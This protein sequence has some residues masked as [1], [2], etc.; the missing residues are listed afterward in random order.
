M[1][2]F[3]L[4]NRF[5]E[6]LRQRASRR[7]RNRLL[8]KRR[9]L[10]L[11]SLENRAL[12]AVDLN[13]GDVAVVGYNTGGAPDQIA[14]VIL[15][16]LDE[17]TVFYVND[18]EVSS[19]GGTGFTD[20]NE[21]E[22][23][24]TVKAGQTVTAGTVVVL[25]WG[26]A[27]V[28]TP[29]YTWSATTGAGLGNNNEELYIY[30]APA[31]TSQTPTE[32]IYFAKIGTSVSSIPNGLVQGDTA[33]SPT[34]AASR[35]NPTATSTGTAA[36]IRAAIGDTVAN[37]QARL[38]TDPL[39]ASDWTFTVGS[40]PTGPE[41]NLLGNSVTIVDGDTA[42]SPSDHTRF[43]TTVVGGNS[44][45][46][47]TI[48][49]TGGAPLTLG[50][51]TSSNPAFTFVGSLPTS[52]PIGGSV[53]VTVRFTPTT[54]AEAIST[55]SFVNNDSNENPYDF[56]VSGLGA[57][58]SSTAVAINEL[59]MRDSVNDNVS[60]NFLEVYQTA[61]ASNNALTGLTLLAISSSFNPGSSTS[62]LI[63]E[64]LPRM[65]MAFC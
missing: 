33:I 59:R 4:K 45:R 43:L 5:L 19:A 8:R 53:N 42:S 57:T 21:M 39:T 27:A 46:T 18:N 62:P 52:V 6:S 23:S 30:E 61:G 2:I 38:T 13:P 36:A 47:F 9:G 24:F 10:L 20:L 34:G 16:D 54:T 50:T 49:N 65:Q 3:N 63:W 48:Q 51:F 7:S 28:D 40:G 29:S 1:T 26:G 32:F 11:E 17:G 14:L 12:M 15:R 41:V 64:R 31:I 58:A 56:V 37:W 22:A 25:P 55:I 60:N 35:F 44:T